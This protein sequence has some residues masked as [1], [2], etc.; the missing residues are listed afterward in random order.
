MIEVAGMYKDKS[1]VSL[2]HLNVDVKL[3][4]ILYFPVKQH[5]PLDLLYDKWFLKLFDVHSTD[6]SYYETQIY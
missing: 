3:K 1:K 4:R 5:K 2:L 6:L